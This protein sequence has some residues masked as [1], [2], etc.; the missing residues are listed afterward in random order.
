[1]MHALQTIIR[2]FYSR[3]PYQEFVHD[4]NVKGF[5]LLFVACFLQMVLFTPYVFYTLQ[6]ESE[7]TQTESE[8]EQ[9][10]KP[11]FDKPELTGLDHAYEEILKDLPSLL[12]EGKVMKLPPEVAQPVILQKNMAGFGRYMV[13]DTRITLNDLS[14][15]SSA[16][17]NQYPQASLIMTSNY[18]LAIATRGQDKDVWPVDAWALDNY[19]H[20]EASMR[21][22][23]KKFRKGIEEAVKEFFKKWWLVFWVLGLLITYPFI[24]L[25]NFLFGLIGRYIL[26]PFT[27]DHF[28]EMQH[29]KIVALMYLPLSVIGMAGDIVLKEYVKINIDPNW[30]WLQWVPLW[31]V[32]YLYAMRLARVA[33]AESAGN[34]SGS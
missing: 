9:E 3:Q 21:E 8:E 14:A 1:M 25:F 4:P 22:F 13:V 30:A 28:T 20:L 17:V 16:L 15:E 19:V 5:K 31:I 32:A 26:Q 10:Y 23:D 2:S 12:P 11:P 18:V 29:F 7:E 34:A 6:N 27:G 33:P 24:M